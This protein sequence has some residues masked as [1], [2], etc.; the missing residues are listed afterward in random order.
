[1][2]IVDFLWSP[3]PWNRN[4]TTTHKNTIG[5]GTWSQ[6][7]LALIEV[8]KDAL[9]KGFDPDTSLYGGV[10]RK[11]YRCA[12]HFDRTRVAKAPAKKLTID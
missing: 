8:S 7:N 4:I 6:C 2:T 10:S 1:M 5:D 9:Q 3:I 12:A 11:K